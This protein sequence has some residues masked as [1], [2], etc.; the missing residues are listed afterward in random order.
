MS[1]ECEVREQPAQAVLS[2]R[3][4]TPVEDLPAQY[5][6]VAAE[7]D[8]GVEVGYRLAPQIRIDLPADWMVAQY[9]AQF[10]HWSAEQLFYAATTAGL[11]SG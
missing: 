10:P 7:L 2:I 11:H 5:G 3:T 9:R 1:Y 6:A 8:G 4:R